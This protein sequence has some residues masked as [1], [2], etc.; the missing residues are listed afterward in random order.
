MQEINAKPKEQQYPTEVI[1]LPSQG[2]FYPE[3]SPLSSG[4]LTLRYPTAKHE[5]ILTSRNLINKG[6]VIDE[7][8]KSIIV[9]QVNYDDILLGDKNGLMIASRILLYGDEYEVQVK[10]PN[11]TATNDCKYNLSDLESKDLDFEQFAKGTNEFTYH[12]PKQ[13]VDIKFRFLTIKDDN[14]INN[15]MK[16]IKKGFKTEIDQEMTTRLS[17][18]ITEY[19]G[20]RS[21]QKIF[22]MVSDQMSS[23]DSKSF[24]EYLAEITPGVKTSVDFACSECGHEQVIPL[25][26]D[27]NFFWPT[28]RL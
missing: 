19:N 27:I 17:Y 25:P 4:K 11:C 23:I 10:C 14:D 5:D 1:T 26:M 18:V 8:L 16:K 12:L 7:F 21:Q 20:E 6:I 2:Y 9:D 22:R 15:Q 13:N 3:T 24:R 28:N